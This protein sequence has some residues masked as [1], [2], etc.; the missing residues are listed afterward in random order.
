MRG[1]L[2]VVAQNVWL[3]ILRVMCV[4]K[5][6]FSGSLDDLCARYGSRIRCLAPL[7]IRQVDGPALCEFTPS[8][9]RRPD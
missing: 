1:P 2:Y 6:G 4:L 3:D 9:P 5:L 8:Y 7:H